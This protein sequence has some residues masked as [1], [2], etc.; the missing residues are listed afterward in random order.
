MNRRRQAAA[1]SEHPLAAGTQGL[2][3]RRIAR[4]RSS[5]TSRKPLPIHSAVLT[6]FPSFPCTRCAEWYLAAATR[7]SLDGADNSSSPESL[8]THIPT[9]L[10]R[11]AADALSAVMK[12]SLV[13]TSP[14]TAAQLLARRVVAEVAFSYSGWTGSSSSPHGGDRPRPC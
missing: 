3:G 11:Q 2:S 8:P 5:T 9:R 4:K 6:G 12:D 14:E 13:L 10:A 7:L 1:V